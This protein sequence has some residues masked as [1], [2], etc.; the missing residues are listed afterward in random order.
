MFRRVFAAAL[1]ASAITAG[2][3]AMNATS[4][5]HAAAPSASVKIAN[6]TFQ[7]PVVTVKPGTVVTWT[8]DDDIPHTV[9]ANN[10]AFKSKVLDSGDRFSFIFAK[11]G[12]YAYFCSLHPHMTGKI[13]VKG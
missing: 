2:A 4:T 8:N 12:E 5:A 10:G 13:I 11:A 6:F 3:L 9:T 1:M 7:A